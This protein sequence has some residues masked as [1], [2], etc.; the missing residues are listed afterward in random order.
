M[1]PYIFVSLSITD[2]ADIM[3]H[4]I[5]HN[6]CILIINHQQSV[7]IHKDRTSVFRFLF[8]FWLS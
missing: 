1:W 4:S 2:M 6:I 7:F 5:V 8:E 3:Q